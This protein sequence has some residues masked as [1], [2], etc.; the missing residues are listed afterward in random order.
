MQNCQA[1]S[2][3]TLIP[4]DDTFGDPCELRP[5]R[6]YLEVA[7]ECVST[8]NDPGRFVLCALLTC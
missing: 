2:R 3:C 5:Y 7:Y 8:N 1:L 4:T 6:H